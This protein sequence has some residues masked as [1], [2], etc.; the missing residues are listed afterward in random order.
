MPIAFAFL[1]RFASTGTNIKVKAIRND[2]IIKNDDISLD[3][4]IDDSSDNVNDEISWNIA[5]TTQF[6]LDTENDEL[7][8]SY[9]DLE[10][11]DY[12][13]SSYQGNTLSQDS[14]NRLKPGVWLN[15]EVINLYCKLIIIELQNKGEKIHIFNSNFMEKLYSDEGIV[16]DNVKRWSRF[17]IRGDIFE[18]DKLFIPININNNHWILAVIFIKEKRIQIYD[19]M[20]APGTRYLSRLFEYLKCEFQEKKNSIGSWHNWQ[21]VP[22]NYD[23]PKQLNGYDCGVFVCM[24]IHFIADN[25]ELLFNQNDVNNYRNFIAYQLATL[26]K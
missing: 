23:T 15:D 5:S 8:Q 17:V 20:L 4:M 16:Y 26:N 25:R 21:L 7:T 13:I 3:L 2:S 6:K 12:I 1:C 10:E 9:F 14:F 18:L 24:F 19:S 11:P 22:C